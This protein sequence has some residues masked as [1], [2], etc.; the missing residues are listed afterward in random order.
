MYGYMTPPLCADEK[1]MLSWWS[2][3]SGKFQRLVWWC[4][5]RLMWGL[6]QQQPTVVTYVR[7]NWWFDN[8]SD[9]D[10]SVLT[11]VNWCCFS[12]KI[13][14]CG[15]LLSCQMVTWEP[16]KFVV[17]HRHTR[18]HV[19]SSA[20][21]SHPRC[22]CSPCVAKLTSWQMVTWTACFPWQQFSVWRLHNMVHYHD[23]N[24][25]TWAPLE[26]INWKHVNLATVQDNLDR[27]ATTHVP[28]WRPI[29]LLI[30]NVAPIM[31]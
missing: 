9:H 14:H 29:T 31:D 27:T 18:H 24:M 12:Q 10:D 6:K 7:R 16:N 23:N 26:K 4:S 13:L 8:Q 30:W 25:T 21:D 28:R 2:G 22:T 15:Y 11:Q 1:R 3:P 19:Y 20:N 5:N 17:Q